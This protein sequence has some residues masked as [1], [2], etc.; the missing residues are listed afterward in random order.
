[1]AYVNVAEWKTEQ[2]C[3]WLKGVKNRIFFGIR[4]LIYFQKQ[5]KFIIC[6]CNGS[7][8]ACETYTPASFLSLSF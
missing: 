6:K 7:K 2:V 8:I 5:M 3:E 1:M 4:I